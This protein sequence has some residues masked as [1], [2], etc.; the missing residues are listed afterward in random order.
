M[1]ALESAINAETQDEAAAEVAT[2]TSST[3]QGSADTG[4]TEL[5]VVGEDTTT[6]EEE[7]KPKD[8]LDNLMAKYDHEE[9]D[10]KY[11]QSDAYKNKL[12]K[13]EEEKLAAEQSEVN[14]L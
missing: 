8:E 4:S 11:L 3:A 9:A 10:K 5:S 13:K 2:D 6:Q 1:A 14:E 7:A 12:K